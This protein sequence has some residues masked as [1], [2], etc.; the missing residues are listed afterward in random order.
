MKMKKTIFKRAIYE[1]FLHSQGTGVIMVGSYHH[2]IPHGQCWE[3]V[4]GGM[5]RVGELDKNGHHTGNNI[6]TL[7]PDLKTALVG[8]YKQVWHHKYF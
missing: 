8:R 7:Y 5:W 1:C 6:A 3:S 4:Q 2:G